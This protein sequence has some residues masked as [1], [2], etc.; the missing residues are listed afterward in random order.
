LSLLPSLIC[1]AFDA[2]SDTDKGSK[3]DN[4]EQAFTVRRLECRFSV[5][6]RGLFYVWSVSG[7]MEIEIFSRTCPDGSTLEQAIDFSF[8]PF[9]VGSGSVV[10]G[11]KE[12][13][14]EAE[15]LPIYKVTV[16]AGF[17]LDDCK[18]HLIGLG[19]ESYTAHEVAAF[20]MSSYNGFKKVASKS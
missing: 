3:S 1:I 17:Q 15:A 20:A 19:S 9:P 8:K 10:I 14:F 12:E 5:V 2:K 16:P 11:H 7:L 13:R 6:W 18:E 4:V